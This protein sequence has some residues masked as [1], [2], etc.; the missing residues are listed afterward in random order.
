LAGVN[1][2]LVELE[3]ANTV[4][5]A[6]KIAAQTGIPGQ[7]FNVG[8]ADGNLGW[9]IMGILPERFGYD[10]NISKR[11]TADWSNGRMGWKGK[12]EVDDYPVVYNPESHRIW[13]GNA[14]IVGGESYAKMG[15]GMGALGAR[16]QQI[17]NR[18]NERDEFE[19][20]DFLEIQ[21][22]DEALFLSRWQILL[23]KT[24]S[25]ETLTDIP[26][27]AEFAQHVGNWNGKASSDSVGYLLVKR[28]RETIIDQT[29]GHVY[30]FVESQSADFW[31]GYVD[32]KAE[33]PVWQLL[34]TRP[35]QHI[36]APFQSW[37]SFLISSI[38]KLNSELSKP[39][40]G[41][42]EQTWGRANT[43]SI[44]HPLSSAVPFLS[45]FLDM[46]SEPMSGDTYMPRVQGS[47]FGASQRMAVSPGH[48]ELGYF[49]MA[50]GQ[51]AHPLS[52]FFG[53]GHEDWVEGIPSPFLP[54]ETKYTLELS[55]EN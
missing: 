55:P 35:K 41:L 38:Q 5:E 15:D 37:D 6:I 28:F 48:E 53:H 3:T 51:S 9:T 31:M 18:L 21:L 36:P 39:D 42:A 44:T 11:M 47:D 34:N 2:G 4:N 8:D 45:A 27:L 20:A 19:V 1:L 46:K 30:R 25:E 43:L 16:Q 22:D 13:T 54:G 29:V 12:L 49:H 23:S 32:N 33:Y 7:N 52:P 40:S 10:S 50:T 17:R 24:L 26:E 14:R